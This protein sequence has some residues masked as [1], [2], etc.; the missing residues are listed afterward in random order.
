MLD[1]PRVNFAISPREDGAGI[2]H[3]GIQVESRAELEE[4]Y[5][6]LRRLDRPVLEEGATTCCYA[7]RV[8][9]PLTAVILSGQ[10]LPIL[11]K[12]RAAQRPPVAH[13]GR[14]DEL[15]ERPYNVPATLFGLSSLQFSTRVRG[16][17]AQWLLETVATFGL[18]R[19][20]LNSAI[21]TPARSRIPLPESRP[22]MCPPSSWRSFWALWPR[23]LSSACFD[24]RTRMLPG[25][26]AYKLNQ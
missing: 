25:G 15:S 6:R 19:V 26:Y 11:P 5:A 1:D 3:L 21:T 2:G 16:V 9:A 10:L 17:P 23:S 13:R 8:R 12:P 7:K 20:I 24:R 14:V 22:R 18:I 4:V